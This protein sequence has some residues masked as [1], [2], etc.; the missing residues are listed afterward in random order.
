MFDTKRITK[1]NAAIYHLGWAEE[2]GA[3]GISRHRVL[4][5]PVSG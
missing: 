3:K 4:A 2:E 5:W 1:I